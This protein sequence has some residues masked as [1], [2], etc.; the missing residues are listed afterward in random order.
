MMRGRFWPDGYTFWGEIN[1]NAA[2]V[3]VSIVGGAG[4]V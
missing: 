2:T 4:R 3:P 1:E